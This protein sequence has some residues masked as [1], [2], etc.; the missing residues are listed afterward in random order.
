[1]KTSGGNPGGGGGVPSS[2]GARLNPDLIGSADLDARS[3]ESLVDAA[4]TVAWERSPTE[5]ERRLRELVERDRLSPEKRD[6]VIDRMRRER[7]QMIR[8]VEG[9]P[10]VAAVLEDVAATDSLSEQAAAAAAD[11]L[12]RYEGRDAARRRI[13][14]ALEDGR[15]TEEQA[16]AVLDALEDE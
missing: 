6:V 7:E 15:L 11:Q 9:R 8:E 14:A 10:P 2:G 5:A 13:E 12:E 3:N 4:L 16:T 1:M